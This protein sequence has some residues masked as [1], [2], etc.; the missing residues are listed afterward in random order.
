MRKAHK[1][2]LALAA[3]AAMGLAACGGDSATTEDTTAPEETTAEET[4]P[5]VKVGVVY[6]G[7]PGD[8]GWTYAHE[9]GILQLES[10][11]GIEVTRLE[12]VPEGADAVASFEQLARDGY[13]LIIGTSFG[14]MDPMLEVAGKFPD[15]CFQHVSGYKTAEN[16]GNLFGAMEE[17]RYLSGIAAAKASKTGKL[18]YVAAFPIPEVVRGLNAFTLGARSVNPDAT[19]QVAWTST[20]YD[21]AIE[22]EAA[23]SLLQAGADVLGM[24]QDSTATGEAAQAAGAKWVGYNTDTKAAD[25]DG[26]WLTA[27][28]WNWGPRYVALAQAVAE[29][30]C[31]VE[32]YY[33]SM[34]DGMINLG[35]FGSDVDDE[36]KALIEAAA[37]TIIDGSFAPFTGPINDN[38][39]TE[40]I[41]AGVTAPLGD[42]LGQSFL[43]EGVIG[44][45][46]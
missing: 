35:A 7:T 15:A 46:E 39:G 23:E 16:M 17:A 5:A 33:G 44:K 43:V 11:L 38:T 24:H 45:I 9:Q 18:G 1:R 25:F 41:A 22:K 19:V 13:N 28:V 20:W 31:P 6:L 27:P 14:Y 37:A 40:Q 26:T 34:A 2:V 3:V 32:P 4:A 21:P 42:L 36:T 10:E 30:S 29:G 12:N 8:G